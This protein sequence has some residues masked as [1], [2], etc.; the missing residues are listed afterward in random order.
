MCGA[1][2]WCPSRPGDDRCGKLRCLLHAAVVQEPHPASRR[3][4][5]A[6][7]QRRAERIPGQR[8]ACRT[9][10]D[11]WAPG[12]G[13]ARAPGAG[14]SGRA[15]WAA[16]SGGRR[17]T[18]PGECDRRN[19]RA[20]IP[21]QDGRG[22]R[23]PNRPPVCVSSGRLQDLPTASTPTNPRTIGRLAHANRPNR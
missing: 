5:L 7:V 3:A 15:S 1:M 18:C 12:S 16:R 8:R 13:A 4:G 10:T 17:D 14:S 23:R 2:G 11:P 19:R 21:A 22:R 9:V 6:H 20:V